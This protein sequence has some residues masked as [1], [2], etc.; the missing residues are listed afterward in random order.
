MQESIIDQQIK[1]ELD[2]RKETLDR[3][4]A[5]FNQLKSENKWSEAWNQLLITLNYANDTLKYS[6]SVL[7][8]ISNKMPSI[9]QTSQSEPD[10]SDSMQANSEDKP[11]QVTAE[12][13]PVTNDSNISMKKMIVIPKHPSVH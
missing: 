9:S 5:K 4:L 2:T 8:D 12:E 11:I 3:H 13:K 1:R 7:K 10:Q 6:S